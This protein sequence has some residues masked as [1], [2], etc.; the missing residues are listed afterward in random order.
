METP[1]PEPPR[2]LMRRGALALRVALMLPL[3]LAFYV[4]APAENRPTLLAL[5]GVFSLTTLLAGLASRRE[6]LT[7]ERV[8]A[9]TLLD[10]GLLSVFTLV[11]DPSLLVAL[12]TCSVLCY[13]QS[14]LWGQRGARIGALLAVAATAPIALSRLSVGSIE[15]MIFLLW[16]V[17]NSAAIVLL[18]MYMDRQQRMIR[19]F[20]Q[21]AKRNAEMA[22]RD[23]LTDLYNRRFLDQR[24]NEEIARARRSGSPLSVAVIDV[25]YLKR[26]NDTHGH[27]VGD[28]A[29]RMLAQYLRNAC[30]T[31]DVA[32]RVGGEEFV[33][34]APDTDADGLRA[35][36]DRIRV[37]TARVPVT[38]EDAPLPR[39]LTF[40]AG[41]ASLNP[42]HDARA[43]L[44][45]ADEALYVAKNA[46]RNRVVVGGQYQDA[47]MLTAERAA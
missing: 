38:G 6:R 31:A 45:A 5:T 19:A 36:V 37:A 34:L 39:T 15:S 11:A 14:L 20:E 22:L 40:S 1:R 8:T 33:L 24:M 28:T 13:L 21:E 43:L 16:A 17:Q 9:L 23:P 29:L 7:Q 44:Q 10:F 25:D 18:G 30:R 35:L 4:A 12:P 46:G 27:E 26:W 3:L 42:A 2:V 32:C 47:I 41:V